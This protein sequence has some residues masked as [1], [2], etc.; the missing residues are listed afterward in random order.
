MDMETRYL[1]A[2]ETP[3]SCTTWLFSF[4]YCLYRS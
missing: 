4:V 2:F 3:C 1:S